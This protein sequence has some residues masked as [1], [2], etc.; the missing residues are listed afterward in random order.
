[1]IE[2]EVYERRGIF[3]AHLLPGEV[4]EFL[5]VGIVLQVRSRPTITSVVSKPYIV[6]F[7]GEDKSWSLFWVVD[8]KLLH[9]TIE[10]VHEQHWWLTR[11]TWVIKC[12]RDPIKTQNVTIIS[13]NLMS[14]N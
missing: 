4:P 10:S 1:L 13:Q 11:S 14:L 2:D 7:F 5:L 3:G 8:N 6:A 9:I 12:T